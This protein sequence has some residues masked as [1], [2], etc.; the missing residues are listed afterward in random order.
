MFEYLMGVM[1]N[2]FCVCVCVCKNVT[3]RQDTLAANTKHPH[4]TAQMKAAVKYL[5]FKQSTKAF[6]KHSLDICKCTAISSQATLWTHINRNM[7][8]SNKSCCFGLYANTV[9]LH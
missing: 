5:C 4:H 2:M 9:L 7:K 3:Q 1:G 6:Y 8:S